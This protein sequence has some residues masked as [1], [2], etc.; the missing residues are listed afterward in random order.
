M[1]QVNKTIRIIAKLRTKCKCGQWIS[2]STEIDFD[3]NSRTTIGCVTCGFSGQ[4]IDPPD[5]PDI[6]S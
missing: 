3:I 1:E 5:P 2:P 4:E 6:L